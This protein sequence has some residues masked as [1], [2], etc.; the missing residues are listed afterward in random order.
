[1]GWAHVRCLVL[2]QTHEQTDLSFS[3]IDIPGHACFSRYLVS[4]R[5][6]S[7]LTLS[8]SSICLCHRVSYIQF[9]FKLRTNVLFHYSF[10][11]YTKDRVKWNR[12]LCK[13][14][15]SSVI[16]SVFPFSQQLQHAFLNKPTQDIS[17]SVLFLVSR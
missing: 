14:F 5:F 12:M 13:H 3:Q 8:L 11:L 4:P 7:L 1:M 15:F 2:Y 16:A 6:V 9:N 10:I 17:I